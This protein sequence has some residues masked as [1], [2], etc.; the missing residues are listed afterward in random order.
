MSDTI[1]CNDDLRGV[2][3]SHPRH[4]TLGHRN[5]DT[6]ARIGDLKFEIGVPL[7][8]KK[9]VVG[10]EYSDLLNQIFHFA[11]RHPTQQK[12]FLID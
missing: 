9:V 10:I 12:N 2:I 8:P 1:Q 7:T 5:G 11:M 6:A 4:S 3:W